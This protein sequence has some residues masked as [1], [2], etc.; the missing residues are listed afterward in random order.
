MAVI[1]Q[2]LRAAVKQNNVEIAPPFT[3]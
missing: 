2:F 3:V 1:E